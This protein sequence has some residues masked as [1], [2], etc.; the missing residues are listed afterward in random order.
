MKV[1]LIHRKKSPQI[2]MTKVYISICI[3]KSFQIDKEIN[4]VII[5]LP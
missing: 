4:N 3:W 5:M 2:D 1:D